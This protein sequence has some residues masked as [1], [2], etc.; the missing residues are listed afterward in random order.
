MRRQVWVYLYVIETPYK[1]QR[2][3]IIFDPL[4]FS[5]YIIMLLPHHNPL[6]WAL[7]STPDSWGW[8]LNPEH[9]GRN[10]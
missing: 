5:R 8:T 9:T 3:K 4:L 7:L 1:K 10:A 6:R 2:R